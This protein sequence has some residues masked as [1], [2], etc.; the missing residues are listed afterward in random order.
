VAQKLRVLICG[1]RN[2]ENNDENCGK[3]IAALEQYEEKIELIIEGGAEGADKLGKIYA[4]EYKLPVMEFPA[5]WSRYGRAAGPIRNRWMLKFGK[6]DLVMAFHPNI[7]KSKGTKNM[8]NIAK[9]AGVK[10][11]IIK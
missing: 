7:E 11:R 2:M 8:V 6:P 3:M 1:D 5:N 4:E 9:K 10:V